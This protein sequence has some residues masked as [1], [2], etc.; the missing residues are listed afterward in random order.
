MVAETAKQPK[1]D[2]AI[3]AQALGGDHAAFRELV[4]RYQT[5]VFACTRAITRNDADAADAAQDAFVRFHRHLRQF[6]PERPLKPYLLR[7]AANCAHTLVARR[8]SA[9]QPLDETLHAAALHDK[10][11]APDRQAIERE[12]CQAVRAWVDSLPETLREVC[13]LFYL[14]DCA[15]RDIAG[16]LEM[17]EGAVK[18]ALHRARTKLRKTGLAEWRVV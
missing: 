8:R 14:A 1:S 7:I 10:G 16:I 9:D 15:C 2:G 13:S 4:L 18:V 5:P 3:V 12:R 17:S 11:T 6:D